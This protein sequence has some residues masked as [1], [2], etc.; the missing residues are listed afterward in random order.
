MIYYKAV[1]IDE[2]G[3]MWSSFVE[4]PNVRVQY[5]LGKKTE[6]YPWLKKSLLFASGSQQHAHAFVEDALHRYPRAAILKC[7]GPEAQT[8]DVPV[9]YSNSMDGGYVKYFWNKA[10]ILPYGSNDDIRRM[11]AWLKPIEVVWTSAEAR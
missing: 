5:I 11:V 9:G 3:N 4:H 6:P 8:T 2:D 7:E 10:N 1:G